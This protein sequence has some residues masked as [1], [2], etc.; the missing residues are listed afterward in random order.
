MTV[1][2]P[3]ECGRVK[4]A[5]TTADVLTQTS[6]PLPYGSWLYALAASE[7]KRKGWTIAEVM[8]DDEKKLAMANYA[9][10]R[11]VCVEIKVSTSRSC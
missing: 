7:I 6:P 8:L 11:F 2:S 5:S 10:L 4:C 3:V 1:S 9:G